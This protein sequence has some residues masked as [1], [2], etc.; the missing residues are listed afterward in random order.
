M[1]YYHTKDNG[2]I[3]LLSRKCSKCGKRWPIM[4]WFKYPPPEDMTKFIIERREKVPATYSKWADR[5]PFVN[6]IARSLP[7]WPR[8][9]RILSVCLLLLVIVLLY[10]FITRGF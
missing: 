7:N 8:W 10:L 6:I 9:A 4:A 2:K 5:Y 3:G 1:P